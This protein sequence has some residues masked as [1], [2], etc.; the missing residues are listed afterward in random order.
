MKNSNLNNEY[1]GDEI[2]LRELLK[3]I[4]S[5]K[6]LIILI[7]LASAL[8]AFIYLAQ[9]EAKY[10]STV[11]IEVG[12]YDLLDDD[13]KLIEPVSSLIKKLNINQISWA[14]LR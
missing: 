3:T 10:Q 13:E 1:L 7:T 11:I 6:K 5:S 4:Y 8:L 2:D 14:C 9:K 12:S